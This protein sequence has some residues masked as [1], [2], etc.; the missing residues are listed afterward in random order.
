[1]EFKY[2][3][4]GREKAGFKGTTG[5]CVTRAIAIATGKDYKEIYDRI[6]ELSKNERTGKKKRDISN[7][8]KGVYRTT[9]KKILKEE[10]FE[11]IPTSGIGIGFKARLRKEDLPSGTII[12]QVSKHFTCVVDGVINDTY[13]PSRDGTRGV[14]GYWRKKNV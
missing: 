1:M 10:G 7:P 2:N 13:N 8:R 14:Y 9:F 12:C 3:D 11:R 4:G 6:Y 5:D